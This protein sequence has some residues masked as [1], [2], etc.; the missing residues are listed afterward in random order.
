MAIGVDTQ[1]QTHVLVV[2]AA[3][4]RTGGR[5][6]VATAPDG[7]ATALQGYRHNAHA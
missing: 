6:A 2:I 1:K 7:W 5:R 3:G 4:G